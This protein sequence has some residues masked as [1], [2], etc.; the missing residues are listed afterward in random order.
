MEFQ[1]YWYAEKKFNKTSSKIYKYL[2]QQKVHQKS[3]IFLMYF[4]IRNMWF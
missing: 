4:F 1:F 3:A 2:V